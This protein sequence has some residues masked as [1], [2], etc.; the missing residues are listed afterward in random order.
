MGPTLGSRGV[1][2][3]SRTAPV[4][5]N[6]GCGRTGESVGRRV[7]EE[8]PFLDFTVDA[9]PLRELVTDPREP[10]TRHGR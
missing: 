2:G 1:D 7:V 3:I 9:V 10:R 8:L 5:G 6:P 4:E